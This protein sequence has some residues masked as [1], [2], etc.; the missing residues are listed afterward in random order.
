MKIIIIIAV[1]CVWFSAYVVWIRPWLRKK[2]WAQPFFAAIEPIE[3][4][5]W[6]KSET[7]LRARAKM[8]LG[9]ILTT[10]T[11]IGTLDITP[12]MP[13]VPEDYRT[14]VTVAFNLIPM[15]ITIGGWMDEKMRDDTTMRREMVAVPM[16]ASPEVK[17]AVVEAKVANEVAAAIIAAE[18]QKG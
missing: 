7:I 16:N 3:I 6:G 10:L 9:I 12:L 13:I 18:L 1:I 15:I 17:A 4:A 11:Q 2:I 8:A 14:M 5:L